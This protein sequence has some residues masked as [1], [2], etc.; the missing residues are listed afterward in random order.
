MGNKNQ[1]EG[2]ERLK[3]EKLKNFTWTRLDEI[4]FSENYRTKMASEFNCDFDAPMFV[5][6][7]NLDQEANPDDFFD[8]A[9]EEER[10][11]APIL[12]DVKTKEALP[13]KRASRQDIDK[14]R[15]RSAI[16][17]LAAPKVARS[18]GPL[19]PVNRNGIN[20]PVYTLRPKT[21]A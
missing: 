16:D 17:R 3:L 11:A 6:F 19:K 12:E 20:T 10:P 15:H 4:I 14:Q 9:I 8:N 1:L 7:E 21:S 5:D 18:I 13:A 2:L